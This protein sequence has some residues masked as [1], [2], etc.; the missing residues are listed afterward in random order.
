MGLLGCGEVWGCV[1]GGRVAGGG[2][3]G[4]TVWW[5]GLSHCCGNLV[6]FGEI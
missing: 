6:H 2:L 4:F 1:G 5:E 3:V